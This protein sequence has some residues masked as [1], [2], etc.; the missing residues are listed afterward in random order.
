MNSFFNILSSGLTEIR[1]HRF[2]SFLTMLGIVLGVSSLVAMSALVQG[3]ENGLKESLVEMG[4]LSKIRVQ[5][6]EDLPVYQE[7]LQG[8]STGLSMKDISALQL[9]A[10]LVTKITPVLDMYGWD[11]RIN[12]DYREKRSRP[13]RLVGS[14]PELMELEDH[15][16]AHGRLFN[17]LDNE[18]AR[19]VCVIGVEI[20]NDL[21]GDPDETDEEI[22]PIGETIRINDIPFTI[23]G[24][25]KHYM[26]SMEEKERAM[27]E[28]LKAEGKPVPKFNRRR[29]SEGSWIYRVKNDS[30]FIPLNTMQMS[31]RSAV[32]IR[33]GGNTSYV[34]DHRLSSIYMKV[35]DFDLLE[36]SLQQVR[37]VLMVT[38]NGLEDWVF[39]TEEDMAETITASIRSYRVSGSIIAAICLIVGGIGITN[40]MLAGISERIKEIGIR[41]SVGA[42]GFDVFVQILTES[43]L[44]A[45]LGG[46]LG[47]TVSVG[48][49]QGITTL[50]P[51]DNSP[52]ITGNAMIFAFFCSAVVGIL[53]G[54]YP[55]LK[56]AGLPPIQALKYES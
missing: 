50:T 41:K 16:V 53:A 6:A 48:L 43:I 9:N 49:V 11:N 39:R 27:A 26:S 12:I 37:N 21:F 28:K 10:P 55:A 52:I 38:H 42:T 44:I 18:L 7:Y 14:W 23:I 3:M 45:L 51:T 8:Q 56:A 17:D 54:L 29:R 15:E 32:E 30:I 33:S 19:R 47:L 1:S 34:N 4:G 2:R 22:I 24:L 46:L 5:D 25:F 13:R 31:F 36:A 35:R 20:R 40:I